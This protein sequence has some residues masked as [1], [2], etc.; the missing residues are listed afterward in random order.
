MDGIVKDRMFEELKDHVPGMF[1]L[2]YHPTRNSINDYNWM[3]VYIE[4]DVLVERKDIGV[5][6]LASPAQ[7]FAHGFYFRIEKEIYLKGLLSDILSHR[8]DGPMPDLVSR[9]GCR[10]MRWS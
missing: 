1:C 6:G 10:W 9:E 3:M 8:W 2:G 5:N 4:K 7:Y